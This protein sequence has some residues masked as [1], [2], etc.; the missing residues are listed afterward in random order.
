MKLDRTVH[1]YTDVWEFVRYDRAGKWCAEWKGEGKPPAW[2]D[3][4][5][6]S[7]W[8]N[9][10]ARV[11]LTVRTAAMFAFRLDAVHR[12]G[13]PGGSTFDRLLRDEIARAER[14]QRQAG[15]R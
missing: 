8:V 13:L 4:A 5:H 1:A 3:P 12:P 2:L 11:P 7:G 9:S 14:R 6:S 15:L 10:R